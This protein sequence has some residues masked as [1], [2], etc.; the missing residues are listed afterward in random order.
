MAGSYD[1]EEQ[2]RL[3]ELKAW[4]EDNRLFVFGAI[5]VAIMAYGGFQGWRYWQERRA[6]DAA[7]LYRPVAEAAKLNDPAKVASAAEPLIKDH[8][9]TFYASDA[10]LV[11][12]KA[13]FEA[14]KLD[15]ARKHLEWVLSHGVEAH[16][17]IARMRLA[18]VL[19]EM[20]KYDEALK[21]LDGNKH[22]AFVA[23]AADQ[24][25]DVMLAQGRLDEAR[26]AYKLAIEKADPRNPVRNL[27]E[28]KLNALGG[29]Q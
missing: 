7:A 25:G 9:G 1:F 22:P 18:G 12:A 8:A 20:K 15:D 13:A 17:G 3:A 10:A 6:E 11:A 28:T 24:R 2:E 27:A 4:W 19:L 5:A 14:G 23:L 21:V 29:A 16:R 26:A